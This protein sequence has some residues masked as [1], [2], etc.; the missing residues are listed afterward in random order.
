MVYYQAQTLCFLWTVKFALI[1][2]SNLIVFSQTL[3]LITK[4]L[5]IPRT[6]TLKATKTSF[7]SKCVLNGYKNS[8]IARYCN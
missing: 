8:S 7:N 3:K 6:E 5:D 4:M 2:L 1:I